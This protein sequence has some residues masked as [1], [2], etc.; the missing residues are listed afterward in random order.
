MGNAQEM[1]ETEVNF[2]KPKAME[3]SLKKTEAEA[4][5]QEHV[6]QFIK[7]QSEDRIVKTIHECS[8]RIVKEINNLTRAIN[9]N[10]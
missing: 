5:Y 1:T 3:A 7:T 2:D 8:D 4:A 6:Q 10:D 9:F